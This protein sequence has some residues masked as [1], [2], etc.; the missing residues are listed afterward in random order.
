MR[1][2]VGGEHPIDSEGMWTE[3]TLRG[4]YL[5]QNIPF[6][7]YGIAYQ[8]E[9]VAQWSEDGRL[10]A[11]GLVWHSGNVTL[12]AAATATDK[13]RADK[14]FAQLGSDLNELGIGY[15]G[16][17]AHHLLAITVSEVDDIRGLIGLLE[18]FE[19]TGA[20]IW[21]ESTVMPWWPHLDR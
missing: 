9:L 2:E 16:S 13:T 17:L 1:F 11:L 5:L 15:E 18:R 12:R 21:E 19:S 14:E 20:G 6:F 10:W 3:K 7:A 4:T 8:D